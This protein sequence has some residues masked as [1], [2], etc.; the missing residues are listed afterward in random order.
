LPRRAP[1]PDFRYVWLLPGSTP[2]ALTL[3]ASIGLAGT[4][5]VAILGTGPQ[6]ALSPLA[7]GLSLSGTLLAA[8]LFVR[9]GMRTA[10]PLGA[11]EVPMAVVPWGVVVTPDTEPRVLRWH[12]ISHVEVH[13]AHVL[14]GGT[15]AAVSSIVT[16]RA[17]REV[18]AGR[19]AGSPGLEGL[20]A[21]LADYAEEAL[22]PVAADLEGEH[23]LGDGMLVPVVADLA[24]RARELCTSGGGASRLSLPPGGYRD[25]ATPVAAPETV[26]L[27]RRA[28][29][30]AEGEADPRPLAAM[31][32]A[33]LDARALIPDLLRLATSPHPVVA[34]VAKAAALKL[35]ARPNRAGAIDEVEAFLLPDDF[36]ALEAWLAS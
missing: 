15:P 35:G 2:A 11:R 30:E 29:V 3:V 1:P 28:L 36:E 9:Q 22:R 17:G 8:A 33:S 32:A 5:G 26:A 10:T 21:N 13:V 12:A 27:L 20:T 24:R 31:V 34:A 6:T 7:V 23:V 16:V 14:R 25:I 19:T 18:L 4:L